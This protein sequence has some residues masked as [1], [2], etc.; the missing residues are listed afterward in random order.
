MEEQ[1]ELYKNIRE[2]SL[3]MQTELLNNIEEMGDGAPKLTPFMV[4][5]VQRYMI[6]NNIHLDT[7][8]EVKKFLKEEFKDYLIKCIEGGEIYAKNK[9]L[10]S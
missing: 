2:Q 3:K 8:E 7:T 1:K 4:E 6:A 10:G 5:Y 9:T